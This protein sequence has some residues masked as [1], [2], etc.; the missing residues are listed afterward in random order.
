MRLEE[1]IKVV[2]ER[3]ELDITRKTRKEEYTIARSIF[4][5]LAMDFNIGIVSQ[6]A[7][8]IDRNHATIIYS[9]RNIFPQLEKYFPKYYKI[10]TELYNEISENKYYFKSYEDRYNLLLD[11]YN[12]L[13]KQT[14]VFNNPGVERMDMIKTLSKVPE[15]KLSKL[16]IRFD[17]VVKML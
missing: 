1:L 9:N 17:A 5:R 13:K 3:T 10:Y 6:V 7:R 4:Y 8:S 12:I 16:K 15:D 14:E 2:S 11:E